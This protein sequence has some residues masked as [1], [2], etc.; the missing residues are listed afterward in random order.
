MSSQNITYALCVL[1]T[2]FVLTLDERGPKIMDTTT[3]ICFGIF[4]GC[5]GIAFLLTGVLIRN[6]RKG[7]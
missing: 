1:F 7:E 2:I 5:Y 6:L 3:L 4:L